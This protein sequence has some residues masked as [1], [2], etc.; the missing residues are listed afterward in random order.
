MLVKV[1]GIIIVSKMPEYDDDDNQEV[2]IEG[3]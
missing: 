2:R 1:E 3:Y